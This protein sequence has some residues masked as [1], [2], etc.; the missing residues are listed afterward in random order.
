MYGGG[1]KVP[2]KENLLG[3]KFN[4][5]T[6]IKNAP[7]RNKHTYWICQCDCGQIC[8]ARASALK[9]GQKKSCGCLN[10][11]TR[12]KLGKS[13]IQNI[14][15]QKFG[16]LTAKERTDIREN[17]TLGYN[18][19]CQCDCG[20]IVSVP[21]TYLKSGNTI[22]C[23]CAKE[24]TGE[25]KISKKLTE[26]NIKFETQ[27]TFEGLYS[28][29]NRLLK[30]DFFLPDLNILIEFDGPQHYKITKYTSP[31]TIQYDERKNKWA[32]DHNITLYRIPYTELNNID[33]YSIE[34]FFQPQFQVNTEHFYIF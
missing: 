17:S 8:E 4:R 3:K 28:N 2:Q 10:T 32:L 6:V 13:H 9:D 7:S 15:G 21:I 24:S 18:W 33:T 11:E 26:Y 14:T 16:L 27:K 31:T 12:S 34:D 30:F 19:I 22:S 20:N 23:G 1:Y 25:K 29:A 5:L